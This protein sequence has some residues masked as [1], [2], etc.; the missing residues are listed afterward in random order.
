MAISTILPPA[1]T[2]FVDANGVPLVGGTVGF[3]VPPATSTPKTTWQDAT[4]SVANSNPVVLDSH[5]SGAIYGAGQ[6][7]MVVKDINGNLIWNGLTQDV[8]ALINAEL[9]SLAYLSILSN[10]GIAIAGTSYAPSFFDVA[11]IS[12]TRTF[13]Q[14]DW[15]NLVQRSN[16]GAAMTDTLP[17]S[18]TAL[19]NGWYAYIQNIDGTSTITLTVGAGGSIFQ[20]ARGSVTSLTILVGERWAITSDGNGAYKVARVSTGINASPPTLSSFQNM[21]AQWATNT[22]A[23]FTAGQIVTSNSSGDTVTLYGVTKTFNSAISGAGGLDTGTLAANTWYYGYIIYNPTTFTTNTLFSTSPGTPTLPA[24]YTYQTGAITVLRTDG[25]LNFI[26]FRQD[27]REYQYIVGSN[28][29]AARQMATGT[30]GTVGSVWSG[31]SVANFVPAP[32]AQRIR[33]FVESGSAGTV[34]VAPNASYGF[35]GSTTNPPPVQ[36][37]ASAAQFASMMFDFS[38]E[39]GSAIQWASNS[40]GAVLA[41]IGFQINI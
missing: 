24:G 19:V 4:Q 33:G 26:G 31:V 10:S 28:L 3:F 22:T 30:A 21:G 29:S 37:N 36:I 32:F 8:N 39:G 25:S 40:A 12:S 14:N 35:A 23:N 6:Y 1:R 13:V 17:G 7:Y 5:G 15:G 16:S 2:V 9:G 20:G 34:I 41:C 27:G 38:L 18:A 11:Y